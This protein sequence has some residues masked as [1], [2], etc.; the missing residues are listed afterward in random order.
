[1]FDV[2]LSVWSL[3]TLKYGG[4]K[5]NGQHAGFSCRSIQI[6]FSPVIRRS[7]ESTFAIVARNSGWGLP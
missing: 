1:M 4:G 6:P 7:T 2:S 5:K 3:N